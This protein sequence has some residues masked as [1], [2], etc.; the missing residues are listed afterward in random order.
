MDV[1]HQDPPVTEDEI[2][3][4][5]EF[6]VFELA[7][8]GMAVTDRAGRFRRVNP[9]FAR[10]LGRPRSELVGSS[11]ASLTSPD[12][13]ARSAAIMR[14]LSSGAA[15]TARFEKRYLR[16]D[17]SVVWAD[18][19]IRSLSSA[20]GKVVAFLAQGVDITDRKRAEGAAA[21][22]RWRLEEAQ[23]IAGMGSFEQDP[24]TGTISVSDELGR[25]LGAAS[26]DDVASLMACTHPDDRDMLG[27]QIGSCLQEKKSVDFVHR[28]VRA[29]QSV[30]WVRVQAAWTVGE[31]GRDKVVGSVLDITDRKQAQDALEYQAFHDTL[32]GLANR[33]L[34]LDRVD[35]A[36]R[37]AERRGAPVAALF[38]D[39]DDFK[40]VNDSL[41]HATGNRLLIAVAERLASVA[42]AGDTVARF[43]GDEFALFLESGPMPET[44]E[45]VARRV[46][47]S[48]QS[49]FL[50][51]GAEVTVRASIGIAVGQPLYDSSDDLL[52]DADLAMHL[53]KRNGK[54]RFEMVRPGLQDEALKHLAVITDLGH[55]LDNGELEVFYQPIVNA[56]DTTPAGAEALVRWHHPRRGLVGPGEFV[57]IAESTG[58]IVPL[59]DWVLNQACRQGQTWRQAGI[60]NDD[61]YISV[62]LS[63]HQLV[64]PTLVDD[65]ARALRSSGLPPGALVLEITES[66]FT[67]DFGTARAQLQSLKGLGL[68]IALD[69]YGT[70]YSSLHRLANLPIDIVKIDKS[71]IDQLTLNR[72]GRALVQSVIDVT[73]ALG[74]TSVAEGVEHPDQSAALVEM[75]C[76]Y[77][78]GYLFAR[79]MPAAAAGGALQQCAGRGGAVKAFPTTG[80]KP[81]RSNR[82]PPLSG[83]VVK[84]FPKVLSAAG[85]N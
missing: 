18:M 53:A 76:G 17:G 81:R 46:A 69:D 29:D 35:H 6:D 70:G 3:A 57:D 52:R 68:R 41:G 44:A 16:P 83:G 5:A 55:A 27:A 74:M 22:D 60:V 67:L 33:A 20:A 85:A 75:A 19:S 43:G 10:L 37:R 7:T 40:V 32:T 71:F 42:R 34:F 66:S 13:L 14:R 82:R 38:V 1:R 72:E 79:P 80:R 39:L 77:L 64:E 12:D 21:L 30:R 59:G 8:V 84:P 61:F 28:L 50:L 36:L 54:G 9:A 51:G 78:Q 15:K 24:L 56:H 73:A 63:P 26:V 11:F 47:A 58:L 65:V 48:L 4:P 23:R 62:N 31:D 49:P 2:G 25:I 45:D